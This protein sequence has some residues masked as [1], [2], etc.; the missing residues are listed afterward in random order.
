[1]KSLTF[2]LSSPICLWADFQAPDV[3]WHEQDLFFPVLCKKRKTLPAC[4]LSTL[5]AISNPIVILFISFN[6]SQYF[7]GFKSRTQSNLIFQIQLC[8]FASG[9]ISYSILRLCVE[10][11]KVFLHFGQ[12]KGNLYKTVFSLICVRF[13]VTF[14]AQ[15]PM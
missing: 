9:S 5:A 7:P 2:L 10:I 15:N 4:S 3:Y 12:S 13:F 14:G 6:L 11:T 1:M 8:V